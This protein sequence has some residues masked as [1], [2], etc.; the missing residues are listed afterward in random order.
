MKSILTFATILT[1]ASMA[2]AAGRGAPL[3][4]A[5]RVDAPAVVEAGTEVTVTLANASTDRWLVGG[6]L[7]G[8]VHADE[9]GGD[10][11]RSFVCTMELKV[12][13]PGEKVSQ[14]WDLT[15]DVGDPVALGRYV[16]PVKAYTAGSREVTMNVEV[17]VALT[18]GEP[19][20]VEPPACGVDFYGWVGH[21]SGFVAPELWA[22]GV[23]T[24]GN[25]KFGLHVQG[26]LGAA[27]AFVLIGAEAAQL[28]TSIG[29]LAIDPTAPFLTLPITL[30][31]E[32]DVPGA[33]ALD[34]ALPI[35]SDP[36]LAGL[37]F[38]GQVVV[39]DAHAS[40]GYAH[41]GGMRAVICAAD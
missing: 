23:P 25:G 8:A 10:V 16:M 36:R 21:G 15:D 38:H 7:F 34:F 3:A 30:G 18:A 22:I 24:V 37:A 11:V 4:E 33:G 31:G 5:L 2:Q 1:A 39:A 40:G 32:P 13:Y 41:S 6:C 35:P 20:G 29:V 9:A 12:L 28:R 17:I 19:G 14:T 27:P 26:G